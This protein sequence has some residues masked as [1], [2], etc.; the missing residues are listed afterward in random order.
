LVDRAEQSPDSAVLLD[1]SER[2]IVFN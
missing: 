1:V 2:D